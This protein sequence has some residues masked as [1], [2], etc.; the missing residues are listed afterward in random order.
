MKRTR[1]DQPIFFNFQRSVAC[2]VADVGD[3]GDFVE[4]LE[5]D[6]LGHGLCALDI[7]I[8]ANGR[9]LLF[10]R[11]GCFHVRIHWASEIEADPELFDR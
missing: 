5:F 8:P 1:V 6:A 11:G 10:E 7:P 4:A 2:S 3:L 9:R